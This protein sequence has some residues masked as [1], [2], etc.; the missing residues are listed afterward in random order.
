[1]ARLIALTIGLMVAAP[2]IAH[3]SDSVSFSTLIAAHVKTNLGSHRVPVV[4]RTTPF[5][6]AAVY[7]TVTRSRILLYGTRLVELDGGQVPPKQIGPCSSGAP[8]IPTLRDRVKRAR[9]QLARALK[10]APRILVFIDKSAHYQTLL[11]VLRS[12]AEA[13]AHL[14]LRLAV[15]DRRGALAELPV[16]VAPGRTVAIR[17]AAPSAVI[18]VAMNQGSATITAHRSYLGRPR[19]A[20]GIAE[21]LAVIGRLQLRSGRRAFFLSATPHTQLG[22]VAE[23]ISESRGTFK[24]V[25]LTGW[26]QRPIISR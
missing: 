17:S 4:T 22:F 13:G 5:A 2:T 26:R 15:A 24:H 14:S 12:A 3:G 1:M 6:G 8:C 23:L 20:N 16:L 11:L 9:A 7:L 25:V 10:M 18:T 19:R 21:I